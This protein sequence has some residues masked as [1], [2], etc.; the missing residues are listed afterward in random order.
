M[1]Y[2]TGHGDQF[3]KYLHLKDADFETGYP[4]AIG[5]GDI[6]WNA[7]FPLFNTFGV[8]WLIVENDHPEYLNRDGFEDAKVTMD[9]LQALYQSLGWKW[10]E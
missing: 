6:E 5:Q 7:L 9:Y 4:T 1:A 2:F 3:T 10:A 8:E